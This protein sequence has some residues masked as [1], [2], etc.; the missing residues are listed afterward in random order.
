[1]TKDERTPWLGLPASLGTALKARS[2]DVQRE[3]I[4]LIDVERGWA[5]RRD[6]PKLRADLAEL[7][8]LVLSRFVA[9]MGTAS[10]VFTAAQRARF[11]EVGAGEAR[12]GRGLED[13]LAAYRIGI[14]VIYAEGT[15]A[16]AE[17]DPSPAAQ[18]AL[19]EAVLALSDVLQAESAEGYAHEVSTHAGERERRLLR[20]VDA[21]FAGDQ[22][23][24]RTVAAQVGWTVPSSLAVLVVP[25]EAMASARAAIGDAGFVVERD[26]LAAAV[27]SAAGVALAVDRIAAA[28]P[29]DSPAV[30]V[31]PDVP[32]AE[33]SRSWFVARLLPE[34]SGAPQWAADRL[35]ELLLRAAPE[36]SRTI[37][38]RVL[39]PLQDLPP[40]TRD[41]LEE[42][43]AAWL[44]HWGQRS[45]VAAELGVHPQTVAYRVNQLRAIF[46]AVLDDPS[47]RLEAQLALSAR[48]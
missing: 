27:V 33:A 1:M 6:N 5:E 3:V 20:L 32:L 30:R 38:D 16:L 23:A 25:L 44:R 24:V 28:I 46:G 19:G 22:A 29:P 8:S 14:R 34:A 18:V 13:L 7:S 4:A 35:P 43:L 45:P 9:V 26:G 37:A 39:A 21:L 41:R 12:E 36:V 17:L 15:R 11:R 10:P 31:G 2:R 47:W 40:A 48:S 42:T